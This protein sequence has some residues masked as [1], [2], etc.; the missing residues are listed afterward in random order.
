LHLV[1]QAAFGA[2]SGSMPPGRAATLRYMPLLSAGA[3]E[4]AHTQ[5]AGAA[6]A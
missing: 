5:P 2:F 4:P 1:Q 6:R 3:K